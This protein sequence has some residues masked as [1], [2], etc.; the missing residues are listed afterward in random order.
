MSCIHGRKNY[1]TYCDDYRCGRIKRQDAEIERPYGTNWFDEVEQFKIILGAV[2][3]PFVRI[4]TFED[5]RDGMFYA[6]V[7]HSTRHRYKN[8]CH[9]V[10]GVD[11][12][13]YVGYYPWHR[14]ESEAWEC[15]DRHH[16][17]FREALAFCEGRFNA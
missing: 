10:D 13:G 6:A 1:C 16:V 15:F 9:S 2:E 4:S 17:G 11:S 12:H 14:S 3:L 5:K 7:A 8:W